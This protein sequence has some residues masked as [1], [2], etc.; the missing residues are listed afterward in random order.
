MNE[1]KSART[2][3]RIAAKAKAAKQAARKVAKRD[4]KRNAAEAGPEAKFKARQKANPRA[5]KLLKKKRAAASYKAF[6]K[7]HTAVKY[8]AA[9][10]VKTAAKAKAIAAYAKSKAVAEAYAEETAMEAYANAEYNTKAAAILKDN[11][12]ACTMFLSGVKGVNFVINGLYLPS[13]ETGL[14]GRMVYRKRGEMG[15]TAL[16]IEH[17][18]G[19][20]QVKN[21][22]DRRNCVCCAFVQGNCALENCHS[23]RW[24]VV[25]DK[26]FRD[27]PSVMI[28]AVSEAN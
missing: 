25:Y 8:L 11:L 18:K 9:A 21:E 4:A 10:E 7:T 6:R 1:T 20:W 17:Y 28:A 2:T 15:D 16:C 19:Q 3:A 23:R 5:Q 12:N 26:E 14:D 22:T 27:Q 13:Q 24:N